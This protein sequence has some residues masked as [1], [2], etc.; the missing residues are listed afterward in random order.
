MFGSSKID[1]KE[2]CIKFGSLQ[3]LN[4]TAVRSS[5]NNLEIDIE[6]DPKSQ[7]FS[8][9]ISY[10]QSLSNLC[11]PDLPLSRDLE[12]PELFEERISEKSFRLLIELDFITK[13][14][15]Y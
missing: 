12:Y 1:R 6:V 15:N 3:Y 7:G 9:F 2:F 8:N 13:L 14:A 10:I 5:K 4:I 11:D